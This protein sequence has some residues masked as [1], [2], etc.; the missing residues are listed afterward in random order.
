MVW[1]S[2]SALKQFF[3][4]KGFGFNGSKSN[5]CPEYDVFGL[6][7]VRRLVALQGAKVQQEHD[8]RIHAQS[9]TI[10]FLKENRIFERKI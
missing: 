7:K 5:F 4:A 9:I 3:K 10:I 1:S 2:G 6:Y 8:L